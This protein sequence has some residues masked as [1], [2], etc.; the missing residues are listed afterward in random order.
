MLLENKHLRKLE[1]EGNCLNVE[2]AK[3]F[4]KALLKNKTLKVLDLESNNLTNEGSDM[5]GIIE[6]AKVI[7]YG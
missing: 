1:L 7:K 3:A 2:S 5:T 6:F 4:G